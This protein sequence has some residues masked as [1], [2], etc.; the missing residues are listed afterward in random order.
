MFSDLIQNKM[1][2]AP[3]PENKGPIRQ[4]KSLDVPP[5]AQKTFTAS[6]PVPNK[7]KQPITAHAVKSNGAE[8]LINA[9]VSNS[10]KRANTSNLV[11]NKKL[12]KSPNL[13][14]YGSRRF[15][16]SASSSSASI[17]RRNEDRRRSNRMQTAQLH[18]LA[19]SLALQNPPA[20]YA[21]N[22]AVSKYFAAARNQHMDAT[23]ANSPRPAAVADAIQRDLM[24]IDSSIKTRIAPLTKVKL[25]KLSP[26]NRDL[27]GN[28][29]LCGWN[30]P[31]SPHYFFTR[32]NEESPINTQELQEQHRRQ[33]IMNKMKQ[34]E[35]LRQIE[36]NAEITVG[37]GAGRR[38]MGTRSH[39][40]I[41][42][43][44]SKVQPN[45][46]SRINQ[47]AAARL[48][49]QINRR[50]SDS[51]SNSDAASTIQ[52]TAK[53]SAPS[54]IQAQNFEKQ[55]QKAEETQSDVESPHFGCQPS[56]LL[57]ASAN[58]ASDY[59]AGIQKPPESTNN[60]KSKTS[61]NISRYNR[62]SYYFNK[63]GMR[64]PRF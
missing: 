42:D 46:P 12:L 15:G 51:G 56:A 48:K 20:H 24:S 26:K 17:L 11:A 22:T 23:M 28:D 30:H 9:M 57:V 8:R 16:S 1:T 19:K 49:P 18:S 37:S 55:Q 54:I 63:K 59:D 35:H 13:K 27:G 41:S 39:Q 44:Y 7:V 43:I 36:E 47:H 45:M 60:S 25:P 58:V 64:A 34:F 6:Q 21:T 52:S 33:R 61:N 53:S 4:L 29:P 40:R 5:P 38:L 31:P 2:A 10:F 62:S 3:R 50:N 32:M 14:I